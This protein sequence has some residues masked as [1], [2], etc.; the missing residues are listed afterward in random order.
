V[1]DVLVPAA[2]LQTL[3]RV[4]PVNQDVTLEIDARKFTVCTGN[5]FYSI[6]R[7]AEGFPVGAFALFAP[8][9]NDSKFVCYVWLDREEFL[10]LLGAGST[11]GRTDGFDAVTLELYGGQVTGKMATSEDELVS[12]LAN[13]HYEGQDIAVSFRAGAMRSL[14]TKTEGA[15]ELRLSDPRQGIYLFTEDATYIQVPTIITL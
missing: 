13:S 15:I 3:A 7:H 5:G 2:S 10:E 8:G 12:V 9:P 11:F 4:I 1:G 14:V 6:Q